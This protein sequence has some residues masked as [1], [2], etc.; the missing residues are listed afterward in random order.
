MVA[1]PVSMYTVLPFW[2]NRRN[3]RRNNS[4]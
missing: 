4:T 1:E 3:N 2:R